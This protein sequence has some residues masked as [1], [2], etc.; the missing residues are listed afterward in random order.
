MLPTVTIALSFVV[1]QPV[2]RRG[3]AVYASRAAVRMSE[4][5]PPEW[6]GPAVQPSAPDVTAAAANI[7]Q[8]MSSDALMK[9]VEPEKIKATAAAVE[10]WATERAASIK[11][12]AS[13]ID[14]EELTAKAK[15]LTAKAKEF[16]PEAVKVAALAAVEKVEWAELKEKVE[17]KLE[18]IKQ[19]DAVKP[20]IE[21]LSEKIATNMET[22]NEA[23]EPLMQKK[24]VFLEE[25]KESI[26][27][28][29]T[30]TIE[31]YGAGREKTAEL[32]SAAKE[33]LDEL[34]EK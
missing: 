3:E 32:V 10:A 9:A 33:K 18:A 11:G 24:E 13:K 15:E 12:F 17:T 7:T 6:K 21:E 30:K 1:Q 14:A 34:K 22:I 29:R 16:K 20:V 19:S 4:E 31:L 5:V 28:L 23:L 2:P 8:M 25:N 27:E 26:E